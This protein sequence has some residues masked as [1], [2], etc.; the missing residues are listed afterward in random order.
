MA[1]I[2][3]NQ[4]FKYFW[5]I[6]IEEVEI[7]MGDNKIKLND[8]KNYI[9]INEYISDIVNEIYYKYYPERKPIR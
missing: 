9:C 3:K 8:L 1:I 5:R 6:M 7:F 4:G 2:I